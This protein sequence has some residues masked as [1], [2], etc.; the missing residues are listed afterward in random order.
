MYP[1]HFFANSLA[2]SGFL[3]DDFLFGPIGIAVNAG[4]YFYHPSPLQ[5]SFY[6]KI[7]AYYSCPFV[8]VQ[9]LKRIT[10]GV[11]LTAGDFTADYVSTEIGFRF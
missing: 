10:A 9:S 8:G 2:A 11:Y 6:Q 3:R 4:Y 5:I 1:D 7:G